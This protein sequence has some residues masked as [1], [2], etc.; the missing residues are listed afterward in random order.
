MIVDRYDYEASSAL[1]NVFIFILCFIKYK[2]WINS[3]NVSINVGANIPFVMLA[4]YSIFAFSEADTYHYHRIYDEMVCYHN[5]IHIEPFYYWLIE[6]LPG[7][8]W[9]WRAVI[10][11]TAVYLLKLCSNK[12]GVESR[13]FA[14]FFVAFFFVQF[15]ISRAALG[16][17]VL[18]YSIIVCFSR[19]RTRLRDV[20]I[21]LFGF[22][23]AIFFHKSIIIFMGVFVVSFFVKLKKKHVLI[24]LIAFPFL[25][26]SVMNILDAYFISILGDGKLFDVANN[27]MNKENVRATTWGTINEFLIWTPRLMIMYL[28]VKRFVFS[29]E[30]NPRFINVLFTSVY[31]LFY[32]SCLFYGQKTSSFLCSRS[33]H[34]CSFPL[35]IVASYYWKTNETLSKVD[36]NMLYLFC[37]SSFFTLA[38]LVYS[39]SR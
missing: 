4:V 9:C 29:D 18:I 16:F 10:W 11:G 15:S 31:L 34:A 35:L 2:R 33:F 14:L 5:I 22:C 8:Y 37:F 7:G 19:E 30:R 25:Y 23:G 26:I 27:Y 38:H 32:I 28:L 3:R 39:W 36:K 21:L 13:Y 1:F 20:I 12:T 17:S 6:L 24:S